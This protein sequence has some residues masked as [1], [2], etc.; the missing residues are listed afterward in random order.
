M[1]KASWET[2]IEVVATISP[3]R[4]LVRIV[5]VLG[6]AG[7]KLVDVDEEARRVL[8]KIPFEHAARIAEYLDWFS[9]GSVEFKLGKRLR[10]FSFRQAA[11]A[12]RSRGYIVEP[13]RGRILI[14]KPAEGF[15]FLGEIKAGKLLG[16]YCKGTLAA[17][18]SPY[19]V[20]P[21]LCMHS[22]ETLRNQAFLEQVRLR[23]MRVYSDIVEILETLDRDA[24]PIPRP[25]G[26]DD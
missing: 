24:N 16:K 23:L 13:Y 6:E 18:M 19:E 25:A 11:R 14:F 22:L 9:A 5:R 15:S 20:P 12:L 10:H 8:F 2:Y 4:L 17:Y 3:D 21:S 7:C 26:D 1:T